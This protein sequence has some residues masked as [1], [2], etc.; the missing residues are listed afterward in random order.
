MGEMYSITFS[1]GIIFSVLVVKPENS[2]NGINIIGEISIAAYKLF[3]RVPTKIPINIPIQHYK[4]A[5]TQNPIKLMVFELKPTI[6]YIIST[7][8]DGNMLVR[9]ISINNLDM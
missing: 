5:I 8:N 1:G 9:G 2:K 7:K 6:K 3:I 4:I